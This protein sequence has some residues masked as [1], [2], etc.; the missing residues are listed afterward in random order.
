MTTGSAA[1]LEWDTDVHILTHPLMLANAAK[2][3]VIT[4]LV[5]GA[6]MS[7]LMAI[8]GD[9]DAVVPMLKM[10]AMVTAAL[11]VVFAFASFVVLR[12]RVHL[13]FK[14]DCNGALAEMSDRRARTA[15]QLAI[16][17]GLVTG[18][19]V[20]AGAGLLANAGSE[21]HIAWSSVAKARFHKTLRAIEL[22][23]SW[24]TMVTLFCTEENYGPVAAYVETALASRPAEARRP[25]KSPL[26]MLLLHTLLVIAACVPLFGLPDLGEQ[27][28]FPALLVL[29]FALAS[30][31]L[32]PPLGWVVFAS[33]VW[34]VVLEVLAQS[35]S[36]ISIFDGSPYRAYEVMSTD[37]VTILIAAGL[38][39]VY[40]VW[41]CVGLMRGTV[42]SGLA[43]DLIE[44]G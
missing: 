21:Q 5:M 42:R 1:V 12:N 3:L 8:T 25:R 44:A 2:L 17:A 27:V 41:L 23:N 37:D 26:P 7:G 34:L 10:T 4:G 18:R 38:A 35:E 30:L 16:A 36:R 43:G 13:R 40:L 28:L 20:V 15:N 32:V 33:L 31:W 11:A 19:P 22:K 39:A 14:V 24:R 6:L 29:C 9:F